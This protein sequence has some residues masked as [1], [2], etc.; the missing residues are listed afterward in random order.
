MGTAHVVIMKIGL[1]YFVF[2]SSFGGDV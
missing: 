1:K 2:L